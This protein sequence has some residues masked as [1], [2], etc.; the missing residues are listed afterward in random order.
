MKSKTPNNFEE[1]LEEIVFCDTTCA[2][3]AD[4]ADG[5]NYCTCGEQAKRKAISTLCEEEVKRAR[6]EEMEYMKSYDWALSDDEDPNDAVHSQCNYR[7]KE[8]EK[9]K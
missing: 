5:F 6:V 1:K 7:I 9:G 4:P 8:L 2:T 3:N